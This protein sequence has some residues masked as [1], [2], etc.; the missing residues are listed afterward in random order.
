MRTTLIL[1]SAIKP[2]HDTPSLKHVDEKLRLKETLVCLKKW[3]KIIKQYNFNCVLVDNT[4]SDA[5][6]RSKIP[7]ATFPEVQLLA[8]PS[9]TKHDLK[10]GNGYGE[11]MSLKYALNELGLKNNNLI[12]K[13]NAR[14]F[15]I[16]FE[17]LLNFV[18]KSNKIHFYTHLR[19]DRAETKFFIITV[20]HL[21]KFLEFAGVRVNI[22]DNIHLESVFAD[23]IFLNAYHESISLPIE[24]VIFGISGRT[25]GKYKFFNESWVHNKINII[26]RK[27]R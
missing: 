21:K 13:S 10:K 17:N 12:I 23:Y 11:L 19:I 25:G 3:S 26:F 27:F 7:F 8:A 20:E 24:P 22:Q 1:T 18:E 14:Y 2:S 5:D 6:L 15:I 16:N 9:L 4:L